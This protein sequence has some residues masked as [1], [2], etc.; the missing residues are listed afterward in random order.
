[1]INALAITYFLKESPMYLIKKDPENALKEINEIGQINKQQND[2]LT[3]ADIQNVMRVQETIKY[4]KPSVPWDVFRYSSLR[5]ITI[6]QGFISISIFMMY[7]GP[8]LIVSQFGFNIYTSET[9]LNVSDLLTYYPL[10]LIIDKVRRRKCSSILFIVATTASIVLIFIT[11]PDNCDMCATVFI[12]L[13]LVFV[14]RFAISMVFALNGIYSTEM[15]PIRVRNI[16]GGVLSI[17]GTAASTLSPIIMGAFT[18]A[19]LSHFILFTVLGLV[20]IGC[21]MLCPE[22]Y[23]KL[24][25][26]E[27]EEIEYEKHKNSIV[28]SAI[29]GEKIHH[30]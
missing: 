26:E 11:N 17:F 25:P 20:A 29:E 4:D 5:V 9:V 7:Y 19:N 23:G 27:I 28:K 30:S 13:S 22:T 12:Q 21:N 3:M 2:I 16:S 18:R 1:M 15:Y 14:F 6:A 8:T 10:M 24:C